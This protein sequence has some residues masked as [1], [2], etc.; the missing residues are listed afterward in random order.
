[1]VAILGCQPKS[2]PLRKINPAL[3][4]RHKHSDGEIATIPQ[5]TSPGK[6]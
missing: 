1:M 3:L 4:E 6:R 5:T 2:K